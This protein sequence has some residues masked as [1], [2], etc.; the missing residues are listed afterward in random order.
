MPWC[1][2]AMV[3][4][5]YKSEDTLRRHSEGKL[6]DVELGPGH[7]TDLGAML[8]WQLQLPMILCILILQD[9]WAGIVAQVAECVS[10]EHEA[11]FKP[12]YW[13]KNCLSEGFQ[14]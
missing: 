7:T 1:L 13:Q 3:T 14:S 4:H 9:V 11:K 10:S 2:Y 8:P 12:R 5:M 6:R